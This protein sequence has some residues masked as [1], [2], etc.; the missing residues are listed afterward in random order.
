MQDLVLLVADKNAQFALRGALQR[1]QAMGIRRI[2]FDFRVHPGRDGGTRK[3]GPE[4]LKLEKRRF[5]HAMLIRDFEG[6]G[7]ECTDAVSLEEHLDVRLNNTW[8]GCAKSIVI[9]PESDIWLWGS[10]NTMQQVLRWTAPI[11]IRTW[12]QNRGYNF[13]SEG[14]P[15]RPKEAFEEVVRRCQL[16]R[17]SSLYEEITGKLSLKRCTDSAYH[18]LAAKLTEWFPAPAIPQSDIR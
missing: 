10:D 13:N 12:L 17:S 5:R 9:E 7:S 3:T 11:P 8:H 1:P 16:P 6:S 14:K 15:E 4:I 18:R 2:E